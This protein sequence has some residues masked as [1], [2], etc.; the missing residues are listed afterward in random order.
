MNIV[1]VFFPDF[2]VIVAWQF[3]S[4]FPLENKQLGNSES[5]WYILHTVQCVSHTDYTESE[6]KVQH[7]KMLTKFGSHI[8]LNAEDSFIRTHKT[9]A[10][11]IW[12]GRSEEWKESGNYGQWMHSLRDGIPTWALVR[13]LCLFRNC[14]KPYPI[15]S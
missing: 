14:I 3:N 13:N 12:R 6:R 2:V 7:N 8:I 4:E 5:T 10:W 9:W 15:P 1:C 11:F